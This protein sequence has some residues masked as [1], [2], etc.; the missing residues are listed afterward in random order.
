M[1][2]KFNEFTNESNVFRG[3]YGH[4]T[5]QIPIVNDAIEAMKL[6]DSGPLEFIDRTS[7]ERFIDGQH[8]FSLSSSIA[9][10]SEEIYKEWS[11]HGDGKPTGDNIWFETGR[12]VVAVWDNLNKKGY[13]IES[14]RK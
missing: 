4:Y 14:D 13:A 1:I 5:I 6:N 12:E 7:M 3:K 10:Q 8:W 11:K 2:K 9:F